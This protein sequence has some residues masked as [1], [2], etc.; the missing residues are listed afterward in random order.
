MQSGASAL[1]EQRLKQLMESCGQEVLKQII[2][3]FGLTPAMFEDKDG[4][5]VTTQRNA[6]Q[7]VFAK[8]S[9]KL[10]RTKD[11]DYSAAKSKK[12]SD[13]VHNESMNSQEF[14]DTYTGNRE[15]TKRSNENGK[16]VM[17]AEL[18][19]TVPIAE[20]HADGG[21]MKDKVGRDEL[22]SIEEN[23]N[24]TTHKTNRR[25]GAKTP[26]DALSSE[27]G[28][29]KNLV[30]PLTEKAR[31]AIDEKLPS[32]S[33]RIKYHSGE[34]L[35]TG[36]EQA[37][38]N[39]LR[40][41]FGVLLHEFANG[42]FIEIKV[43]LVNKNDEQN[44]IDQLIES[45]KRVMY[46]VI[47]KLKVALDALLQG[48]AQ[49]F[50]SNVLTFLINNLITTA[51]KFVTIIREGMQ[52]LWQAIKLILNPP[53]DMPAIEAARQATKIIAAVVTTGLGMMLDESVK[54]FIATIPLLLPIADI[55]STALTAIITGVI[56]AL[57][58]YGLDRIFDWLSSTGTE[59]LQAYEEN[60]DSQA[61]VVVQMQEWLE[62]QFNQSRQYEVC[63]L[64]YQQVHKTYSTADA[65]LAAASLSTGQSIT[66]RNAVIDS[67]AIQ[68][69]RQKL[70]STALGSL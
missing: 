40:Q 56:S 55:L 57:V 17:N 24:Y 5:N 16:L 13:A 21:W 10:D 29:D 67:F 35:T 23:L 49:G 68:L 11:Y 52:G 14:V 28:F 63:A 32:T 36:A 18:D 58:V 46:R 31:V 47:D 45:L 34:L 54:V 70:L 53:A 66:N 51:K 2:G 1:K 19:H 43:L 30:E 15:S 39:A 41:A 60:A 25:K 3:P 12:K 44:L 38:L 59:L 26:E 50:I 7:G 64:K 69:E 61:N 33:E 65:R 6:E 22:S 27:N 48:G 20:I 42:S 62:L 4:G 9:E 8:D 37:G